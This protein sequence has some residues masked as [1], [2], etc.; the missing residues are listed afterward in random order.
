MST[1]TRWI[2]ATTF[3]LSM[4]AVVGAACSS[5]GSSP[6]SARIPVDE[7]KSASGGPAGAQGPVGA[8]G[9]ALDLSVPDVGPKIVKTASVRIQVAD[10]TFDQRLQL[11]LQIAARHGGF[12]ASSHVAGQDRKMGSVVI[13]VP[14][15]QFEAALGEVKGLGEVEAET[16]SGQDVTAQ[17]VD[18]QARL[19]NWES[20]ESVLL[21][22]MARATTIDESIKVQRALQDVQLAIE[23]LRGQ[24]HVLD[25]QTSYATITT[26]IAEAGAVEPKPEGTIGRAWQSARE[27]FVSVVGAIVVGAGYL[28][29]LVLAGL[30]G[31]IV[32]RAARRR[33]ET[34]T[35]TA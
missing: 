2:A 9:A 23:E 24:L 28:A 7:A 31:F 27:G 14:S 4:A 19:R 15:D 21:G 32:W 29:P 34:A 12:E 22:L 10:G 26:A 8:V 20:Q 11:M 5:E 25:D 3:A 33:T 18:L 13:R 30:V 1:R 17:Y 35:P 16:A 6:S